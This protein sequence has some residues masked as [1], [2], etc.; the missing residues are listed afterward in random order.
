MALY[1]WSESSIDLFLADRF[2]FEAKTQGHVYAVPQIDTSRS[3]T[4]SI[5]AKSLI[6]FTEDAENL[7]C[8]HPVFTALFFKRIQGQYWSRYFMRDIA[9]NRSDTSKVGRVIVVRKAKFVCIGDKKRKL[10]N[11]INRSAV[12]AMDIV[13]L[14]SGALTSLLY[15]FPNESLL[16]QISPALEMIDD[17]VLRIWTVVALI[18]IICAS[19]AGRVSAAPNKDGST[20]NVQGEIRKALEKSRRRQT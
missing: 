17:S 8:K 16:E 1:H 14:L 18:V 10:K 7:F 12:V 6:V 2:V 4:K 9:W 13:L 5:N 3:L 19:L 15:L 11:R 20:W